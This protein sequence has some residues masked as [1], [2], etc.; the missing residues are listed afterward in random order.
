MNKIHYMGGIIFE[1]G[2][3][4]RGWPVCCSGDLCYQIRR[5]GNTTYDKSA[6]TCRK[7]LSLIEKEEKFKVEHPS[8]Y[9]AASRIWK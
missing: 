1:G 7:C 3:R 8:V 2:S 6:V 5:K 4:L 9:E